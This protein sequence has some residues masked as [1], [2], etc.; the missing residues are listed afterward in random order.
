MLGLQTKSMGIC[1]VS[2]GS[3]RGADW[4]CPHEPSR[5]RV[6]ILDK[7]SDV[8]SGILVPVRPWR[9]AQ[10]VLQLVY[11]RFRVGQFEEPLGAIP[12]FQLLQR[13]P[14]RGCTR[15]LLNPSVITWAVPPTS[16]LPG[17][18][19]DIAGLS[20]TT[21]ARQPGPNK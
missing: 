5:S 2:V 19:L 3:R 10:V 18:E 20:T 21:G 17:V 7:L 14:T 8:L 4:L 1:I 16:H 12:S 9:N 11:S 6:G 13:L 15:M